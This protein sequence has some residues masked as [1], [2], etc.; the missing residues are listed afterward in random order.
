MA[1][2]LA[3]MATRQSTRPESDF[4][5][6]QEVVEEGGGEHGGESGSESGSEGRCVDENGGDHA[7]GGGGGGAGGGGEESIARKQ[8][9]LKKET[10]I[11]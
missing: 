4:S 7:G 11:A 3:A 5:D 10:A 9:E 2:V 1:S 8:L 6:A